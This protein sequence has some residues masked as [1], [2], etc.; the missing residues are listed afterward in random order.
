MSVWWK[1]S[2]KAVFDPNLQ[3]HRR[4]P[5]SSLLP[6]EQGGF[7]KSCTSATMISLGERQKAV[8]RRRRCIWL[9]PQTVAHPNSAQMLAIQDHHRWFEVLFVKRNCHHQHHLARLHS[10]AK[11]F[12]I[13]HFLRN[14]WLLIDDIKITILKV[15]AMILHELDRSKSVFLDALASLDSKLSVSQ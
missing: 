5:L 1:F 13:I 14:I 11:N 4:P 9:R 15:I 12:M 8:G 7:A 3:D 6:R 10:N 2:I